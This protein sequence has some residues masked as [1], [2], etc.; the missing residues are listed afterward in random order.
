MSDKPYF[1]KSGTVIDIDIYSNKTVDEITNSDYNKQLI[2]YLK[3]QN[4]YY[5]EL[6]DICKGIIESGASYSDD[7]G[8]IYAR[9]SHILDPNY[10]WKDSENVFNNMMVEVTVM[11]DIDLYVGSKIT[12]RYGDKGVVSEL[13]DDD[14]MPFYIKDGKEVP[15][16][17]VVN[18]LSCPN[19]L[20]PFQWIEMSITSYA[21]QLASQMK[22]MGSDEERYGHL[23][24]FLS[25]FNDR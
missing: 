12:G 19:R 1:T 7:I 17:V 3:N 16:D 2:Y 21:E 25:Y 8:Y 24:K 9:A 10:R 20:N 23:M 13:I 4:R 15:L 14:K 18:P 5:Q 22:A 11:R 6:Y